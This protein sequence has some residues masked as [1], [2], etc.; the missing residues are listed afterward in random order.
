M[1]YILTKPIKINIKVPEGLEPEYEIIGRL[2]DNII[3][4]A[5]NQKTDLTIEGKLYTCEFIIGKKEK[6][7][8]ELKVGKTLYTLTISHIKAL[9]KK[10]STRSYA[11]TPKEKLMIKEAEKQAKEQAKNTKKKEVKKK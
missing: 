9:N 6:Y 8:A 10:E 5:K 1:K 7:K 2:I 3:V 11:I 4:M